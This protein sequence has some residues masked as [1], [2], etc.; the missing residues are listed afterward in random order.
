M[1]PFDKLPKNIKKTIRYINQD[2]NSLEDLERLEKTLY[3]IIEKRKKQ[4]KT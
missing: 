4:L 1:K 3:S 2:T